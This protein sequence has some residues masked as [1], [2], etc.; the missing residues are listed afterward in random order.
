MMR[1]IALLLLLAVGLAGCG[2]TQA[3][4]EER[5]VNAILQLR[6]E[7]TRDEELPGRP[8]VAVHLVRTKVTDS[9]L[10]DLKEFKGLRNL[11]L[12]ETRI[13]DAG[14]K[15]LKELKGLQKLY[16]NSTQITDAGLKDLKE[17][18]DLHELDL[19]GTHQI[20]VAGL[21]DL[22]QALPAT[23]IMP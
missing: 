1:V 11:S 9:D 12:N 3:V 2:Q 7:V 21:K 17:L 23:V 4:R 5:A 22:K 14:L 10:K 6:G 8:I 20:T 15:D 13:T 16:L 18:K 19:I